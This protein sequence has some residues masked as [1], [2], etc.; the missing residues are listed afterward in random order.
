LTT[1]TATESSDKA[2]MLGAG[3]LG[4]G[5][6][7]M[8]ALHR[9]QQNQVLLATATATTA[10]VVIAMIGLLLLLLSRASALPRRVKHQQVSSTVADH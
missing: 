1:T 8:G 4:D 2:Q 9:P 5:A 6:A 10:A 7:L 3:H